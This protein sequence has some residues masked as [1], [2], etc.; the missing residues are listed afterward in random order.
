LSAI[1]Q[2]VCSRSQRARS[3]L[4]AP[5]SSAGLP[6]KDDPLNRRSCAKNNNECRE[7]GITDPPDP[8][9]YIRS[10]PSASS[11]GVGKP[12]LRRLCQN[13]RQLIQI[14]RPETT[15][16]GHMET[17]RMQKGMTREDLRTL[18]MILPQEHLRP[19]FSKPGAPWLYSTAIP[20]PHSFM[21]HRDVLSLRW[22]FAFL[23][24]SV[25]L[26]HSASPFPASWRLRLISL[27]CLS[28][29]S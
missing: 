10:T 2:I 23:I 7:Y 5:L 16:T 14:R 4:H 11:Q 28:I 19:A 20:S 13:G 26:S 29:A 25:P 21:L 8:P 17:N 24:I 27:P 12:S 3:S 15:R 22:Q 1:S 18:L 9:A 6:T